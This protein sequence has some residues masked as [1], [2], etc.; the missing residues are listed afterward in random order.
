MPRKF[1]ALSSSLQ[2]RLDWTADNRRGESLIGDL[3]AQ[4]YPINDVS[5][6]RHK[7]L[8]YASA[9]PTLLKWLPATKDS[10]AKQ[11][12]IRAL[13]VPWAKPTAAKALI[14]EFIAAPDGNEL[15]LRWTIGNALSVVADDSVFD[16][17]VS[18]LQDRRYGRSREMLALA[19]ANMRTP[20]AVDVLIASLRDPDIAGHA[21]KALGK[22]KARR[23]YGAI[24]PFV[25]D[26]KSWVRA[27]AKKAL[28]SID[29]ASRA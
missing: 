11:D 6:L 10:D 22:L 26:E 18:L 13:S 25:N 3:R 12:V 9:I 14:D 23:A 4:G 20:R 8:K 28:A 19:L 7:R 15:G 16:D 29:K 21:I 27:E 5:D 24:E 2:A 17:V 1:D